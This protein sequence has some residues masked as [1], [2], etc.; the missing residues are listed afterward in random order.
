MSGVEEGGGVEAENWEEERRRSRIGSLKKK[1]INASSRFTHS[2][3]KRGKR[4]IDFRVPIE[5]VRDAKE[6]SA[7]QELRQRLLQKGFM[8][9]THDDYHALLRFLKARDFNIEKTMQ[10]WEEMLIWR[11]E[12]G[13]D[14]ILQDFEF[15]ELEEVLQHYPQGYHGVDKEGRPVYIERLGKAHPSRLMRITTI[16]R[17]LK[18]HVQEFE[19][20]LQEKFPAC[21]I[22]AKRRISSTTTILDVQGLGIKNFSPTAASL[23]AAITKI[24]NSY[25]PETLHRMYII[26]AGLGFKRM[27]WPAAQKFLDAKTIAKIQVLEPKSTCKLLDIID[28]SQLP[29]FLGGSCTCPGEGGCLRSSKGPWNDADIMK[30]QCS[31]TS[32]ADSGSDLDDSFSSIS[33]SRFTFPRLAPVHEEVRVADNFHSCCD[34][35]RASAS[36]KVLESDEFHITRDPS[37][38]NDD[39]ANIACIENAENAGTSVRSWFSFVKEKV[40]QTNI[41]NMSRVLVYFLE[42]LVMFFRSLRLEFWRTQNNIYPSVATE[43]ENKNLTAAGETLSEQNLILQCTQRLEILEKTFGELSHKPAGIPLEKE[44]M[45][46]SSL[47]RIKCVEFDLEKTKRVLHATVMKQFEI[48]EL[49]EN[50]RASNSQVNCFSVIFYIPTFYMF[51]YFIT[52]FQT[53]DL[54]ML[55]LM[56]GPYKKNTM[57]LLTEY[58]EASGKNCSSQIIKQF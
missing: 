9:P 57:M 42:R 40:E 6:E 33:Q 3:K 13:T 22:A 15:E 30:G 11:K 53:N 32:T 55:F 50:L 56:I 25:Y 2:L 17:Y 19:K 46:M 48:A 44:Q 18:Y 16:D 7:V 35:S 41:L 23:L 8:P 39:T 27:L 1:A 38:Q 31:D 14:A 20:A 51:R 36:E 34:D 29:E 49:V 58:Y 45:L 24:D 47:D 28:S 5:D 21:S 26:N 10:M 52:T 37:L 43:H 54:I 12:F 4:K